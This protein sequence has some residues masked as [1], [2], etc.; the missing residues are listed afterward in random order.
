MST[1]YSAD[2]KR[3]TATFS[4]EIS[5]MWERCQFRPRQKTS[6]LLMEP[7]EV[8]IPKTVQII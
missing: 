6:R 3:Q 5:T 7:V 8:T 1:K 2:E 4:Y